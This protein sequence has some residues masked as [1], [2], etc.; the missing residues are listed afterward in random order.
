MPKFKCDILSNFQ[1][2]CKNK[3]FFSDFQSLC[4]LFC[5]FNQDSNLEP[6]IKKTKLL[7]DLNQKSFSRCKLTCHKGFTSKVSVLEVLEFLREMKKPK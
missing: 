5:D 6:N 7:V 1:T 4:K 3:T 2:M